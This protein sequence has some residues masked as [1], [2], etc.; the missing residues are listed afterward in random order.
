MDKDDRIRACYQ[1]SCLKFVQNEKMTNQSLRQRFNIS[2]KNY[3]MASRIISDTLETNLIK[4]ADP[5]NTSKK[6]YSYIP[7]WA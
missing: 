1:H 6:Y 5:E 3:P 7:F 2:E 4:L